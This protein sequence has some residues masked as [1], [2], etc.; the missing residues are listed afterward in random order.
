M[1]M[2]KVTYLTHSAEVPDVAPPKLLLQAEASRSAVPSQLALYYSTEVAVMLY[3]TTDNIVTIKKQNAL[4][5][6]CFK[7]SLIEGNE[8]TLKNNYHVNH[9]STLTLSTA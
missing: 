1:E 6:F 2:Y 5:L 9:V 3:C 4:F 7:K 8:N